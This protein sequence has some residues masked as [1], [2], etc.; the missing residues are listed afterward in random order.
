MGCSQPP[1]GSSSQRK[2]EF[3]P[4]FRPLR[5]SRGDRL[6]THCERDH[7]DRRRVRELV[8]VKGRVRLMKRDLLFVLT[9]TFPLL[10]SS[11]CKRW[12][13]SMPFGKIGKLTCTTSCL[14]RSCGAPTRGHF[15]A[16]SS[17]SVSYWHRGAATGRTLFARQQRIKR[18]T[19]MRS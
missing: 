15:L 19:P 8:K 17:R 5:D 14:L 3:E 11:S 16:C 10:G 18:W 1:V 4:C 6:R 13:D 9:Q 12:R 7:T 2:S